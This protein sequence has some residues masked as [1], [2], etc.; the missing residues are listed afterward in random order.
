[1][2]TKAKRELLDAGFIF[3]TVKGQRPNKVARYAETWRALDR[4]PGYEAG[5]AEAFQRGASRLQ[6]PV[7]IAPPAPPH[8]PI[9]GHIAPPHGTE[10]APPVPPHGTIRGVFGAPSVLPHGHLSREPSIASAAKD[11]QGF[12]WVHGATTKPAPSSSAS[13][14]TQPPRR[15]R[16]DEGRPTPQPPDPTAQLE[17]LLP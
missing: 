11:V 17:L 8:G 10:K 5:T 7:Q 14:T 16:M 3:E 12:E 6:G 13:T 9:D 15:K 1:M 2:L 4:H